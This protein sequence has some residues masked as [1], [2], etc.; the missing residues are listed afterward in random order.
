MRGY[1]AGTA[2]VLYGELHV[3]ALCTDQVVKSATNE[4]FGDATGNR[5]HAV[6]QNDAIIM[7]FCSSYLDI[8]AFATLLQ[9]S[10]AMY[11]QKQNLSAN[12]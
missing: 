11:A 10:N 1:C 9:Q 12:I 3:A 4:T 6:K 8:S 5:L 2:Q 7:H